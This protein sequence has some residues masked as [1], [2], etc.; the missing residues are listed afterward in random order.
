MAAIFGLLARTAEPGPAMEAMARAL[1]FRGRGPAILA[2]SGR[3]G[4]GLRPRSAAAHG[5]EAPPSGGRAPVRAVVD[6]TI[7][8][9]GALR[10]E[11]R[12]SGVA[13]PGR[14]A[15]SL[16]R[17]LYTTFGTDCF[18]RLR[19]PFA[20][21]IWDSSKQ[22]LVLAR[23]HLGRKPLHYVDGSQAFYFASEVKA[24]LRA[25]VIDFEVDPE[26]LSHFL[27]F[28]YVPAPGCLVKGARKV[29]PAH[30]LV[31][32]AS[33][34][35]ASRF[36]APSYASKQPLSIDETLESLEAK[37]R[38]T[39][40]AHLTG[41]STTGA[42]LSAGLDSGLIVANMAGALE[43]P[44]HTF[45][46]GVANASDEVPVAHIVADR[47]GTI[48]H[49]SYPR[50]DIL[51]ALPD[52]L[53]HVDEPSDMVVVSK[54]F[55]AALAAPYVS[56]V[57]AGDGGDELFAGFPRYLGVRDAKYF[58]L[59]P[60]LMRRWLVNHVAQALGGRKELD[61]LSGKLLWLDAVAAAGPLP[62]RYVEAV[63]YLRF[64]EASKK[65]LFTTG[66]WRGT[67]DARSGDLLAELVQ[68]SDATH[69]IEKML[70]ADL[71]TRLPE[72]L[73]M[74]N[75]RAG[76]AFGLNVL[77]PLADH[78]LVEHVASI[79]AS[80]KIH[81]RRSKYIEL[82]LAERYLPDEVLSYGKTGWSFPF[83]DLCANEMQ[84]FLHSLFRHSRLADDDLFRSDTMLRLL[85]EHRQ[86]VADHHI[87]L[88]MLMSLELWY[89]MMRE[90]LA[91]SDIPAWTKALLASKGSAAH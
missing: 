62:A 74:L 14:T 43:R 91:K 87:R 41:E 45:T 72:H 83:R 69:P 60:Q 54:Y 9:A 32:T 25:R 52:M 8:N 39:I 11:L 3:A 90:G 82:L 1:R 50:D 63:E 81:G 2:T 88:W 35:T 22:Q 31:V 55:G 44:F 30:F 27:S 33:R 59:V 58:A 71:L 64:D 36:W 51:R 68:R 61:T 85:E 47:Y 86:G 79:P 34:T 48:P 21:A 4:I 56:T 78:E 40:D 23:D 28:R 75:D 53:W 38:E 70:H 17:D 16:V 42:F 20:V 84:P 13:N 73:L 67:S 46:L 49:D 66:A 18:R 7:C 15:A 57:M 76:A 5:V 6:G 12:E 65:E 77:C 10:R 89:R 26:S 19:G 37:L 80:R 24:L 29:P